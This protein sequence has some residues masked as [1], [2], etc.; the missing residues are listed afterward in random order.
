MELHSNWIFRPAF[1]IW[2]IGETQNVW[3]EYYLPLRVLII[4][5]KSMEKNLQDLSIYLSQSE[6]IYLSLI[7]SIYL[8]IYL[9]QSERIY[10][11]TY[12]SI[13]IDRLLGLDLIF[14]LL[15]QVCE[16]VDNIYNGYISI[17]AYLYIPN[18]VVLHTHLPTPTP[19]LLRKDKGKQ[20]S[21][22]F[23]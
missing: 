22:S 1:T 9:S 12:L 21:S 6:R 20:M 19:T 10:L 17:S 16:W 7:V 8:S 15:F 23:A 13:Q 5:R 11:S 18:I 2:K 4:L 3:S 14:I